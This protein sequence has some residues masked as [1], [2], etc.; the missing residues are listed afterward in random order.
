MIAPS[1]MKRGQIVSPCPVMEQMYETG[2]AA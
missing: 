2:R 1:P